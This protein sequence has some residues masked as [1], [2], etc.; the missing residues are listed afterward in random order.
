MTKNKLL[1]LNNHLF[2]A[3]ERINDDELQGEKLQEEMARAKTITQIGNTIINNASLA[4][5]AK[6][7]KDEFG[8]GATLPLMIENGK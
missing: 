7:Y 4:L 1:D 3:L 2:E 8:R 5:E 6:K